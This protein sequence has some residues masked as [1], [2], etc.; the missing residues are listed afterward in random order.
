[1][2]LVTA[3]LVGLVT[4]LR[5]AGKRHRLWITG[6]AVTAMLPIQSFLLPL[7]KRPNLSL[8]DPGYWGVQPFILRFGLL[9]TT[10]VAY[11]RRRRAKSD[12][13]GTGAA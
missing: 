2:P 8:S 1:M 9:I 4:G 5:V 11:L 7:V 6:V 12:R 3:I 13:S 10:G